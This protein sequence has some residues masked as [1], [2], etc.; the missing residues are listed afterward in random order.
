MSNLVSPLK[1]QSHDLTFVGGGFSAAITLTYL[2]RNLRA[3]WNSGVYADT[4]TKKHCLEIA[5]FDNL[6]RFP[7]G[8]A[9][10]EDADSSAFFII[11]ASEIM[12]PLPQGGN[13]FTAWLAQ[14]PRTWENR[15]SVSQSSHVQAWLPKTIDAVNAGEFASIFVPRSVFGWFIEDLVY[16]EI[17]VAEKK[18]YAT[19]EILPQEVQRVVRQAETDRLLLSTIVGAT[20]SAARLVVAVGSG[21][22]KCLSPTVEASAS[23]M[24]EPLKKGVSHLRRKVQAFIQDHFAETPPKVL[25]IGSN[26]SALDVIGVFLDVMQKHGQE[27]HITCLSSSGHFPPAHKKSTKIGADPGS[28]MALAQLLTKSQNMKAQ[29]IYSAAMQDRSRLLQGGVHLGVAKDK[30]YTYVL[31]LIEELDDNEKQE[32]VEVYGNRLS[33]EFHMTSPEYHKIYTDALAS[34]ELDLVSGTVKDIRVSG[35]QIDVNYSAPEGS[36]TGRFDLVFDCSGFEFPLSK[37]S[38]PLVQSLFRD[39]GA[40]ENRSGRGFAA[41]TGS[42]DIAPRVSVLGPLYAGNVDPTGI[43]RWHLE[44]TRGICETAGILAKRLAEDMLPF[45]ELSS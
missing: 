34:G 23:M 32:F 45:R 31:P 30:V 21:Q 14:S 17:A 41:R 19:V 12:P 11:P 18:G 37:S 5:V 8:C 1:E 25:V 6:A 16:K 15:L 26:A 3:N 20:Y 35:S 43:C 33:R 42:F 24:S 40:M 36:R 10:S 7:K 9:Y 4:L 28:C 29:E 38:S 44:T 2:L 13:D 22:F 39:L 27:T